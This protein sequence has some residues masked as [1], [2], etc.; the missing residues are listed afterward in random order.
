M[1]YID[2]PYIAA[3]GRMKY[4][5]L[6]KKNPDTT[7]EQKTSHPNPNPTSPSNK[8]TMSDDLIFI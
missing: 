3:A 5:S 6:I 1:F 4:F 7:N 8:R 2:V